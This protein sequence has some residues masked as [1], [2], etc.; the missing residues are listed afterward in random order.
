MEGSGPHLLVVHRVPVDVH[1]HE[2]RRADEVDA[3]RPR[4]RGQQEHLLRGGA[5]GR[6]DGRVCTSVCMCVCVCVS[7]CALVGMEL[8]GSGVV[9][10]VAFGGW[11][12]WRWAW[13]SDS[14]HPPGRAASGTIMLGSRRLLTG[15]RNAPAGH[16]GRAAPRGRRGA[17]G[18]AGGRWQRDAPWRGRWGG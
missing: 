6:R 14:A 3:H 5:R 9:G 2:A 1:E 16:A 11:G 12:L 8:W 13:P 17:R 15:D 18:A 7:V 4:T 10:G